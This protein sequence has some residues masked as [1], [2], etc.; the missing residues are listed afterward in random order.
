MVVVVIIL[1]TTSDHAKGVR[2]HRKHA[3]DVPPVDLAAGDDV[4]VQV[5]FLTARGGPPTVR[6]R[7]RFVRCY[8]DIHNESDAIWGQHW[9][10]IIECR[11]LCVLRRPFDIQQ[12]QKSAKD[13]GAA[14][15]YVYVDPVDETA[16]RA[17]GLLD[18]A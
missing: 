18:C 11:D 1:K 15:R 5:T 16:I 7:M 6:Y 2:T 12:V 4:L 14:V 10:Y 8:P 3:T 9:D 17:A 13:Y